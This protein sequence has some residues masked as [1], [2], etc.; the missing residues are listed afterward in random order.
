MP[1]FMYIGLKKNGVKV[2]S[3]IT[4]STETEAVTK[5]RLLGVRV[6]AIGMGRL[7]KGG[8]GGIKIGSLFTK[9]LNPK[10]QSGMSQMR[11]EDLMIFTKQMATLIDAGIS[12]VGALDMLA[13]QATNPDIQAV[14]DH[15]RQQV[16]AGKDFASA[17]E[18]HPEAFDTTYIS[19][20]RAGAQSG[21]L[22]VMMKKLTI[23]IEKS[24]KLKKQLKSALSYPVVVL[25]IAF[26]LSTAMIMFVVPMFAKNY[27][28][29]GKELPGLTQFV[30]DLSNTMQSSF[31][32]AIG[33]CFALFVA[34]VRWKATP[35]GHKQWDTFLLKLPIFGML[36]QKISIARFTGTL[37]TLVSSGVGLPEALKIC[38]QASGNIVIEK[39]IGNIESGIVKGKSL[40]EMMGRS[41]YFPS[42][43][44]GM[45]GIGESTGRLDSMLEKIANVYEEDVESALA[46]ALKMVEPAMFIVVGGIVGFIL[47]AMY[48]PIFDMASTVG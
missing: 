24:N 14:I 30:I 12:I 29:A 33:V 47:L 25:V 11:S 38:A 39:D 26:G 44:A 7:K 43:V 36:I 15:V 32:I 42:M 31:H 13:A 40:A 16:E 1:E 2:E 6:T 35:A 9:L 10:S 5:L 17:L 22:D 8:K 23:Y 45:V 41:P 37:A 46:A 28:D 18:K 3:K 27:Q 34:F 48:L 19:L 4:A 21:Q 20:I